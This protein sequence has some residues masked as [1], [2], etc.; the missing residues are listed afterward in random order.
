MIRT[1]ALTKRYRDVTAVEDL[2]LE[3]EVGEIYGFLGPN[4][5]GKTTTILMLL[6][7]VA[8]TRGTVRLF[9]R[10]LASEPFELKR[11]VGVVCETQALYDDMT[12]EE[13][14]RFFAELYDVPNAA[15][16]IAAVVEAV[17]LG[18]RL[19]SRVRGYS[20]GM[21]QKLGLA[22]ALLHN[23]PLLLLDE[24]VSGLDP[25]GI[26]DVRALLL[27][28]NA[29]GKTIFISSHVLSEVERTA[30][31]VG[32]LIR[33]KLVAQGTMAELRRR[34]ED[35]VV[36]EVELHAPSTRVAAALEALP[37]V[38]GVRAAGPSLEIRV[39]GADDRRGD[40]SRTVAGVGGVIVGMRARQ[41]SLEDAFLALAE[42][43]AAS[44]PAPVNG[45]AGGR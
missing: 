34:L 17:G 23:P 5:A 9:G 32:V 1:E 24:P 40:V 44:E 13:Y 12:A 16:R 21:Q 3:V 8:P 4:G 39:W 11:R 14:L 18:D 20:R 7:I 29:G 42:G 38:L 41:M 28:E 33:G 15:R 43:A 25:V 36:L 30:H 22:R 19:R 35:P 6:G 45:V 37:F 2:D 27:R 31:R 26:R 10:D